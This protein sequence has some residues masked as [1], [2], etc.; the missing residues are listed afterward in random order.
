MVAILGL[1]IDGNELRCGAEG[2][3]SHD[4]R[5]WMAPSGYY[6]GSNERCDDCD[7]NPSH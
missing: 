3:F 4:S 5:P 6:I 7:V 2:A 1:P